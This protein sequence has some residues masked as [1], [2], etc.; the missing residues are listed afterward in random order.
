MEADKAAHTVER[1]YTK[2]IGIAKAFAMK[3]DSFMRNA[4]F[5]TCFHLHSPLLL[6]PL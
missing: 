5:Y 2:Y 1:D 3:F 4:M 6:E